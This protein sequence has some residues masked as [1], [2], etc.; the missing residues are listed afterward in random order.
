VCRVEDYD[1]LQKP[2]VTLTDG[3]PL[4]VYGNTEMT[5][6]LNVS[7]LGDSRTY[8][9]HL[10]KD[11]YNSS[12]SSGHRLVL[13]H[14]VTRS[15]EDYTSRKVR[16]PSGIYTHSYVSQ[17]KAHHEDLK[18][19]RVMSAFEHKNGFDGNS[20]VCSSAQKAYYAGKCCS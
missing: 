7:S 12:I 20:A 10:D 3:T 4:R 9:G 2:L 19:A 13:F 15:L 6:P 16:L 17:S 11:S 5:N 14:Y 1:D 8:R 18:D